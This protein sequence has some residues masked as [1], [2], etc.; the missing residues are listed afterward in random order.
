MSTNCS[1]SNVTSPVYLL[2]KEPLAVTIFRI[3]FQVTLGFLGVIG[4][5]TVCLVIIKRPKVLGPASQYLF[6]LAIA[7]LCTLIFNLPIAILKEEDPFGW[8]L[9]RAFC[10]Y[11]M[12]TT[13]TFFGAAIFSITLI[14]F[15][16]YVNIARTA[17]HARKR[18]SCKKR[19]F[20]LLGVWASSFTVGSIPLY[21]FTEYDSCHRSC[22]ISFSTTIYMTYIISLTVLW[23]VFPLTV[24]AF[25]Y[26]KIAHLVSKR[27]ASLQGMPHGPTSLG[28]LHSSSVKTMLRQK[29]KTYRI[30]TPLVVLFAVSM[31][32]LTLLRLVAM[33][34]PDITV[35]PYYTILLTLMVVS[36]IVNSAADPVIYCI[37]NS[38]FR[39][40]VRNL[41][42][43][44]RLYQKLGRFI[45]I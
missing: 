43:I 3:G 44:T 33:F 6:S 22:Y 45:S 27:T 19:R 5:V 21:V 36:T 13:E 11:I 37:V 10:L 28:N 40:Q 31:L 39:H 20:I 32:P 26:I 42:G 41:F 9:G 18:L 35:L 24:I 4:N 29:R 25:S 7:D 15:E 34:W 17:A 30:L 14:G 8:A 1:E 2:H 23:Y 38:E 12:P 16:R